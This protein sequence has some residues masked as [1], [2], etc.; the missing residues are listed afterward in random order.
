MNKLVF[1]YSEYL[2]KKKVNGQET[3]FLSGDNHELIRLFFGYC[4]INKKDGSTEF[5]LFVN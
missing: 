2:A 1:K 3:L 4:C 5:T